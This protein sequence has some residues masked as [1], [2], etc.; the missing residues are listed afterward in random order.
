V[1]H[2]LPSTVKA[3]LKEPKEEDEEEVDEEDTEGEP[4]EEMGS[5][6]GQ[7]EEQWPHSPVPGTWFPLESTLVL[8]QNFPSG[9]KSVIQLDLR[10]PPNLNGKTHCLPWL[11]PPMVEQDDPW[12]TTPCPAACPRRRRSMWVLVVPAPMLAPAEPVSN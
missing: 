1:E 12:K 6:L 4:A 11:G 2:L 8:H 3:E 5:S 7:E 10:L 9:S